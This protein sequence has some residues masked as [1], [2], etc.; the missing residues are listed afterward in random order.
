MRRDLWNRL[1]ISDLDE[2]LWETF[3]ENSKFSKYEVYPTNKEAS[4]IMDDLWPAMPYSGFPIINLP[5]ERTPLDGPL[6]SLLINRVTARKLGPIN[7]ELAEL[8]SLLFAAYG[9]T[10][11][12]DD[13]SFSRPFR[14]IP[15]AGAMYPLELFFFTHK[16]NGLS[17]GLYHYNPHENCL[18]LMKEE[19]LTGPI[20]EA[21]AQPNVALDSSVMF[22]I[23]AIF[24]RE[25]MK[26]GDRG[27]RFAFLEAGHMGQN[28]DL[29]AA[30]LGLG[31]MS[32]GGFSDRDVDRLLNID[33]IM[34][35]VIYMKA[36]GE[37]VDSTTP[38]GVETGD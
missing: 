18:R 10:R 17:T 12:N 34:H 31:S 4:D 26:Y 13:G 29:A 6:D 5:L 11:S 16:V 38:I 8:T 7:L 32:I 30:S 14:T 25:T 28:L 3:H 15:S 22:F 33:G 1:R 2:S 35:S 23:S 24:A 21:L 36:V 27:Y 9:E 37:L 19:N 20:A